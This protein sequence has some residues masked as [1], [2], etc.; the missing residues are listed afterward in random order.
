MTRSEVRTFVRK[1]IDEPFATGTWSNAM[2]NAHIDAAYEFLV[3][4]VRNANSKHYYSTSTIT[5]VATTR[6]YDLPT[7]CIASNIFDLTDSDGYSLVAD[8]IRNFNTTDTGTEAVYYDV[9]NNDVYLDPVPSSV[10][11]YTL[12]Y[13]RVPTALSADTT[14]L[15]FP[16]GFHRIVSYKAAIL[17]KKSLDGIYEDINEEYQELFGSMMESL[18]QNKFIKPKQISISRRNFGKRWINN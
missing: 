14:E 4:K 16:T 3:N 17:A 7:D 11:T 5:T 2:L 6:N 9:V 18:V 15:D 13:F 8:D 10:K 1:I 12:S